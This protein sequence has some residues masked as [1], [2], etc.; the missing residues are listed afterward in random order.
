VH[1][2]IYERHPPQHNGGVVILPI[3]AYPTWYHESSLGPLAQPPTNPSREA[4]LPLPRLNPKRQC[5]FLPYRRHLQSLDMSTDSPVSS[6]TLSSHSS[7][8]MGR[9]L[10]QG[11]TGQMGARRQRWGACL[12]L[13]LLLCRG[14]SR[15]GKAR[16]SLVLA[17][18]FQPFEE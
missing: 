15:G 17:I 6:A 1:G 16:R 18:P 9:A 3:S 2:Y 12:L 5:R 10:G 11:W 4:A 13:F 14:G 8:C 7:G